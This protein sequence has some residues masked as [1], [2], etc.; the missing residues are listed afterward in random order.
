MK[1]FLV[2]LSLVFV[3]G[4]FI[5]NT[6]FSASAESAA[7]QVIYSNGITQSVLAG[8]FILMLVNLLP[9]KK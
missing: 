7:Q 4:G 2:F 9:V 8:M 5:L 6:A 1:N 3:V